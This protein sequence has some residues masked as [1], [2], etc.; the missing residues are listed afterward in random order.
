LIVW[1]SVVLFFATLAQMWYGKLMIFR[2]TFSSFTTMLYASLG[3][4]DP[5]WFDGLDED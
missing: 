5:A 2:T 1:L 3:G 4:Y